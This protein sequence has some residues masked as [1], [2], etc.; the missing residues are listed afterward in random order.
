MLNADS[1]PAGEH[2]RRY[3]RREGLGLQE[4]SVLVGDEPGR[5]EVVVR[6]RAADR[7]LIFIDDTYW[8]FLPM[9]YL[10]FFLFGENRWHSSLKMGG[11][12][13]SPSM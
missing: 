7:R 5:R 4:V 8:T 10:L 13:L 12:N 1:R 11:K 9:H 6:P 3:N 2:A